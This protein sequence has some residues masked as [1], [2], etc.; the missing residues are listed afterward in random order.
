MLQRMS[1]SLSSNKKNDGAT[2]ANSLKEVAE[3][4]ASA[5]IQ[6]SKSA[7]PASTP[8]AFLE[9]GD[10]NVQFPE[11]LLWK[12]RSLKLDAGG[13]LLLVP[14]QSGLITE[15]S[16]GLKKYHLSEFRQA[17]IPDMDAQEMPNSVVMNFA[18]GSGLQFA[19][20]DRAGQSWLLQSMS[21]RDPN[22][23][24]KAFT[25][26]FLGLQ[27]AHQKWGASSV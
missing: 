23:D 20:E 27:E 26:S 19:C 18:R 25:N 1:L 17:A 22:G 9:M 24:D 11:N 15:K 16:A 3:P 5:S 8:G 7:T 14:A 6:S 21:T 12:R 2:Q 13:F 4:P 10:V